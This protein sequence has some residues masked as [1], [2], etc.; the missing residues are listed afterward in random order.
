[1]PSTAER[2]ALEGAGVYGSS[3]SPLG[4]SIALVFLQVGTWGAFAPGA[5]GEERMAPHGR[6]AQAARSSGSGTS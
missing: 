5:D 2:S 4:H 6:T 3:V 1:M